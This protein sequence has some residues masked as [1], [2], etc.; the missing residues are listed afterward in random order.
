MKDNITKIPLFIYMD[1]RHYPPGKKCGQPNPKQDNIQ[2]T[3]PFQTKHNQK[4]IETVMKIK[5]FPFSLKFFE[6]KFHL[7]AIPDL[8][9]N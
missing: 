6:K 4:H 5:I 3:Q 8:V 2:T 7:S 9:N 1:D